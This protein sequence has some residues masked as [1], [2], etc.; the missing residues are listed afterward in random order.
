[1]VVL[2]TVLSAAA[3]TRDQVVVC[4]LYDACKYVAFS[5]SV[6]SVLCCLSS[7]EFKK[8]GILT[9]ENLYNPRLIGELKAI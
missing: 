6:G 5:L 7:R 1:V 9:L 8:N 2:N 4:L 3:L